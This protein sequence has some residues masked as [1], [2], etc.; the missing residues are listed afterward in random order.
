MNIPP[1]QL[2]NLDGWLF[3][4]I[5]QV[6]VN[7]LGGTISTVAKAIYAPVGLMLTISLMLYAMAVMRG[8]VDQPVTQFFWRVVKISVVSSLI[9]S[10][11]Y[12]A[13]DIAKVIVGLPDALSQA[14]LPEQPITGTI[15][16]VLELVMIPVNQ[17]TSQM[18]IGKPGTSFLIAIFCLICIISAA[19][20]S[21]VS[22]L[23]VITVKVALTLLV[24]I[25]PIFISTTLFEHTKDLFSRWVSQLI[26]YVLLGVLF[27]LLFSLVMGINLELIQASAGWLKDASSTPLMAVMFAY[28]FVAGASVYLLLQLPT[29]A[30][31]LAG[32]FGLQIATPT[33]M[34]RG[35]FRR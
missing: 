19:F 6:L 11:S 4:V 18:T 26:N 22:A 5:D 10:G 16:K 31:A 21:I 14:I 35:V 25:G 9:F 8:M 34:V 23:L 20:L 2:T 15:S 27:T 12:Y 29:I 1:P 17:A 3:G 13:S 7:G 33:R 30:S 24:L 28:L 32:G